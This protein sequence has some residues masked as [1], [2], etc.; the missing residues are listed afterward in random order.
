MPPAG[1]LATVVYHSRAAVPLSA[2]DLHQLT[3]AAQARNR[4]ESITGV[5]LY[6]DSHF[7]QWLEGPADSVDRIMR[8]IRS[9]PRHTD[10]EVL[11]SGPLRARM[12][13]DW[14]MKFAARGAVAESWRHDILEP[15]PEIVESLRRRPEAAPVLLVKLVAGPAV[16]A[17][18]AVEGRTETVVPLAP[19]RTRA[20]V[21]QGVFLSAVVPALLDRH[22]VPAPRGKIW[23]PHRQVAELATLLIAADQTEAR[24]LIEELCAHEG[25][26]WPLYATLFEPAARLLGDRWDRDDCSEFDVTLGLSRL[27]MAVRHL[28]DDVPPIAASL[29]YE[30]VV[31]IAPEPG[32]VHG[33]GAALDSE[34][35]WHAGWHPHCEFPAT[36]KALQ[37][38]LAAT[39]FDVLDLSLSVAFRREDSLARVATTIA[40]ARDASRNPSIAVIVGGRVFVEQKTAGG[41]VGADGACRTAL[42][43]EQAIQQGMMRRA[44]TPG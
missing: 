21:L 40:R 28:S 23:R 3:V 6:D 44:A 4:A 7:F 22:P 38:L 37:D 5:M 9:D 27:R 42:D 2:G 15:P 43:I 39:W 34:V 29:A 24:L 14:N 10:I 36:D 8:S 16:A 30:P 20:S 25:S 35:L 17:V 19:H 26:V 1:L 32:E 33:L 13:A 41:K 31:L 18:V 11:D 12:F